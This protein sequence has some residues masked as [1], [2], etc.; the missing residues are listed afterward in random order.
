MR[1]RQSQVSKPVIQL[2]YF[3]AGGVQ[4][5]TRCHETVSRASEDPTPL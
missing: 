4:V 2:Q 5:R 1:P 3:R